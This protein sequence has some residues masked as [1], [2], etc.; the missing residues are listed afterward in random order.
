MPTFLT[1][2][3]DS[4]LVQVKGAVFLTYARYVGLPVALCIILFYISSNACSVASNFWLS[5]WSDDATSDDPMSTE[6]RLG[7]YGLLGLGQGSTC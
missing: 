3:F 5:E 2:T 4:C 1:V 6:Y 7:V